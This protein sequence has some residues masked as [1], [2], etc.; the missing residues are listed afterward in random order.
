MAAWEQNQS[1]HRVKVSDCS[2]LDKNNAVMNLHE[3]IPRSPA[4]KLPFRR[5]CFLRVGCLTNENSP[6]PKKGPSVDFASNWTSNLLNASGIKRNRDFLNFFL[7]VPRFAFN[8]N[9]SDFISDIDI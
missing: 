9:F 1:C 7:R 6:R 3:V 5:R 2:I 8:F 4:S